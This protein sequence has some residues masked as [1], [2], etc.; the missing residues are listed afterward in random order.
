LDRDL[1]L[2]WVS[3]KDPIPKPLDREPLSDLEQEPMPLAM[4]PTGGL[5]QYRVLSTRVWLWRY[6]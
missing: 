1:E 4:S 2:M 3:E 6:I 5:V